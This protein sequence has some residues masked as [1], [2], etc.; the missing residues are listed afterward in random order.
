MSTSSK[1]VWSDG[2]FL[3][4]QHFQQQ[5]R[6]LEHLLDLRARPLVPYGWGLTA[7]EIDPAPLKVGKFGLRKA[8]GI[9]PDGTPMQMP[10]DDPLPTAIDIAPDARDQIVYL[11][12]PERRAGGVAVGRRNS[13]D[14]L[15]RHSVDEVDA[16]DVTEGS[17]SVATVDVGAL[18]TRLLLGSEGLASYSCIPIAHVDE[19]RTD[20]QVVLNDKFIPT[21]LDARAAAVLETFNRH[22]KGLLNQR[23]ETLAGRVTAAGGS[24]AIPQFLLLLL[25][26]RLQ[27]VVEHFIATP[28]H[29]EA[30]FR[31]YASAI[32]ELATL[33][34]PSKRPPSLP[35]YRHERLRESFEP[36][37]RELE[38]SLSEVLPQVAIPIDVLPGK[39]GFWLAMVQ[40]KD[41]FKDATFVL[42]VKA[43]VD[44]KDLRARVPNVL[45]VGPPNQ[46]TDLVNRAVDSLRIHEVPSPR[47]I[48]FHGG[49]V[50]FQFDQSHE[51]WSKMHEAGAISFHLGGDLPDLALELWAIRG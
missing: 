24:A 29:P 25:V 51:R 13:T 39:H 47:Q 37:M 46:I 2:L 45:K 7:L 48:P 26:N 6:Y 17:E 50:Y 38:R 43:S 20:A 11:C 8:A 10:E 16:A 31:L 23:A 15:A 42:G 3:R 49:F 34:A 41:L 12:V 30:L 1:V 4:P 14:A 27:P 33:T 19:R 21:V 28:V 18:R 22:L 32:G 36:I 44:S 5:E 40:N 9:F 35:V